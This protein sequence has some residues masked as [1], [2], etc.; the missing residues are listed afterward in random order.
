M[1]R[2][3]SLDSH[4]SLFI[5]SVVLNKILFPALLMLLLAVQGMAQGVGPKQQ[6][7]PVKDF[8]NDWLVYD[9]VYKSYIPYI[10]EQHAA[11]PAVS[12]FLDLESNRR[13]QLLVSTRTDGYLFIDA[14][15][16]L[17]LPANTWQVINIDS[18]YKAYRKHEIFL[19]LYGS[20][21]VNDKMVFIG[22]Q[23]SLSQKPVVLTD[24]GMSILPRRMSP[25][26]NFFTLALLFIVASHALLFNLFQRAFLRFFSI[27]DL[28]TL[29]SREESFLASKPLSRINLLFMLNLSFVTAFT[30]L[31]LE[32]K[33]IDIFDSGD[34]LTEGQNLG[35]IIINFFELS[36]FA[37][38]AFVGKY[39]LILSIGGLYKLEEMANL[40][41]FKALQSSILFF[42]IAFGIATLAAVNFPANQPWSA[43]WILIPYISFYL[44]RLALLYVAIANHAAIKNLYL[45][46]YLC[47]VELIPLII[48]IRFAL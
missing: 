14:S 9:P 47:I 27:P 10:D 12:L 39:L 23:K 31:L 28:L 26:E 48:G 22:H 13:Y 45:F 7:Y 4:Y 40:H 16:R 37:F 6:F 3:P 8:R 25:Y 46:S 32:N 41:F 30:Y 2:K 17:R 34:L 38:L 35:Q 18:L 44:A 33:N 29:N 15:L 11:I 19:T 21:G 1:P 20:P 43:S 24:T 36:G 5:L 42:T